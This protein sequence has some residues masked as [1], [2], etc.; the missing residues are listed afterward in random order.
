MQKAQLQDAPPLAA[1]ASRLSD[2]LVLEA[3]LA[4]GL[5]L[6]AVVASIFVWCASAA[7]SGELT[8]LHDSAQAWPTSGCPAWS[9]GCAAATR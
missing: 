1:M 2:R 6:V 7:G 3:V 9:S 8:D 4:G 5:G